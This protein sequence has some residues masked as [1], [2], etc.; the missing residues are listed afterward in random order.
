MQREAGHDHRDGKPETG[1]AAD[2]EGD[3]SGDDVIGLDARVVAERA[4]EVEQRGIFGDGDQERAGDVADAVG[5]RHEE[6]DQRSSS[7]LTTM[8]CR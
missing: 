2:G 6:R 1:H 4:H 5:E 3:R 8:R 7:R